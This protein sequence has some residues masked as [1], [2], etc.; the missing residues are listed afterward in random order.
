LGRIAR[1]DFGVSFA[2]KRPI[3]AKILERLPATLLL[4]VLSIGLMVAIA[5][6]IGFFSAIR[7]G[8]IFDKAMT[9]LV[10]IGFSLPTYALALVLM[11]VFG[12][13]LG[14][15]PVS[16]LSTIHF[17]PVSWF[18]RVIDVA[19]HLVL[20]V[21]VLALTSLASLSRYTRNS[22]LEV[23]HQDYVRAAEAKGLSWRRVYGVHAARNA[24][25]PI[26]TLFGLMLPD[27][28]GGA[29]I[30]ETI[31]AYPGMGRLGY[32]AIMTRDYNLIMALTVIAGALTVLGNFV[33][34]ILYAY[35]DPRIRYR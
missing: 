31:F 19:R 9:V 4:N 7:A 6:P 17:M 10:F 24:L 21:S 14:W 15:L 22:M 13:K 23:I 3:A 1:L 32:D 29:V 30:I 28:I 8:S 12:L 27:L 34:D 26:L 18:D 11:I 20:P 25:I 33:A 35:A 16:G 2:D 5:L